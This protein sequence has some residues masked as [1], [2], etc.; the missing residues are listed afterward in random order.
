MMEL[1]VDVEC[2]V[3]GH[4]GPGGGFVSL[5][6]SISPRSKVIIAFDDLG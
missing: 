1:K 6:F 5:D 4:R 2:E 3:V